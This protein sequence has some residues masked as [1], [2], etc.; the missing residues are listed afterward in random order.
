MP[1]LV[2]SNVLLYVTRGDIEISSNVETGMIRIGYGNVDIFDKKRSKSI[3]KNRGKII[4]K[5][6]AHLGHGTRISCEL[7]SQLIFGDNFNISAET[8]IVCSK[9]IE[10]DDNCLLSWGCL[11]ID[12]DYH[13][14]YDD[15]D[16][17]INEPRPIK[18][19]KKVWIGS[20]STILKGTLIPENTIIGSNS[21]VAK[22]ITK[23]GVYVGNPVKLVKENIRWEL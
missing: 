5:G 15:Q 17:I 6:K 23:S 21:L 14:I 13:K 12:T 3:W 16:H 20:R 22:Q 7:N 2:S 19:G 18:I 8:S 1:I 4:F 9:K 10:F 11:I